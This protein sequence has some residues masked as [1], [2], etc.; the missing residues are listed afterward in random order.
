MKLFFT[1][2]IAMLIFSQRIVC[3]EGVT[4]PAE[5][6][7]GW[8]RLTKNIED[9]S[10]QIEFRQ[11]RSITIGESSSVVE[12]L[13][14]GSWHKDGCFV[15]VSNSIATT[16]FAANRKEV[17]HAE[18]STTNSNYELIYLVDRQ[19]SRTDQAAHEVLGDRIQA[20]YG[21]FLHS[22]TT[23]DQMGI[24]ELVKNDYFATLETLSVDNE[25]GIAVLKFDSR[26][27]AFPAP[28]P[29]IYDD[30]SN[31]IWHS[32][33]EG[34]IYFRTKNDWAI[35]RYRMKTTWGSVEGAIEY[36]A[37]GDSWAPQSLRQ[38]LYLEDGRIIRKNTYHLQSLVS[39]KD[40]NSKTKLEYYGIIHPKKKPGL[41]EEK[42]SGLFSAPP[43]P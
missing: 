40:E 34:T 4:F 13:D 20:W 37:F 2:V 1:F 35:D 26:T 28:D 18:R 41:E 25:K 30:P 22:A 8:D 5:A 19:E 3:A 33:V 36:E 17:F 10:G 7:K 24:P 31:S 15:S 6:F 11:D 39:S 12:R 14:F 32:V 23:I 38:I 43:S 42:G 16:V 27:A 29:K 21:R 9:V